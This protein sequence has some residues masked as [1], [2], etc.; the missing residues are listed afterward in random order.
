M[1]RFLF[2]YAILGGWLPRRFSTAILVGSQIGINVYQVE[3]TF[4]LADIGCRLMWRGIG[5]TRS[6]YSRHDTQEYLS[7]W[8]HTGAQLQSVATTTPRLLTDDEDGADGGGY[9]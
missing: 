8:I 7:R 4:S 6:S 2:M 1:L 5:S 3:R 9:P